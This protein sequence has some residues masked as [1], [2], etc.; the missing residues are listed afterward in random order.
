VALEF[1]DL[2]LIGFHTGWPWCDGMIA[3]AW[4]HPNVFMDISAHLPRYLNES[5]K[6]FMT[7]RGQNKVLFGTNGIGLEACL[8]QFN[9]IPMKDEVRKK[10][11]H[12]NATKLFGL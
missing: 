12:E 7:T 10:I 5:I 4:K 9:E 3:M 8:S 2:M 1:R 11:L 6:Q